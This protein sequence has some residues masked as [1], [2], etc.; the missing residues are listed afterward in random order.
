MS[1]EKRTKRT[2]LICVVTMEFSIILRLIALNALCFLGILSKGNS[3]VYFSIYFNIWFDGIV[4]EFGFF[5][6]PK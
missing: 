5:L 3:Y 6:S 1:K 4:T 2:I